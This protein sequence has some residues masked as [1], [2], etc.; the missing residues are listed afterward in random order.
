MEKDVDIFKHTLKVFDVEKIDIK[1]ISPLAMAYIGDGVY[2]MVIRTYILTKF[3]GTLD[4]MHKKSSQYVKAVTQSSIINSIIENLSEKEQW[5]YKR[6]RN[7]KSASVA[8][9]ATMAEYRAATGF[10]A[11]IGYLYLTG[12]LKRA[13]EIIKMGFDKLDE[14]KR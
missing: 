3:N 5:I 4:K 8:K 6:G 9:N 12:E 7:A 14:D 10:E 1:T 2:E 13:I 11:L